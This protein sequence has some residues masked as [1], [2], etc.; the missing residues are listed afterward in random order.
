MDKRFKPQSPIEQMKNRQRVLDTIRQNPDWPFYKVVNY[1]RT[2][3][4]L[5]LSEMSEITKVASATL[6]KM[7]QPNSN[8]TLDSMLK[9]LNTF[10][11]NLY[12]H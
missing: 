1:L 8:P 9:V 5:T 3:L 7:E 12:I 2:E 6:Q 4:H 11:L 10:G